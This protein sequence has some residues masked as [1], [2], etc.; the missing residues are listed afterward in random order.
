VDGSPQIHVVEAGRLEEHPVRGFRHS[1]PSASTCG[2]SRQSVNGPP[3][4]ALVH[5]NRRTT[6]AAEISPR[7]MRPWL[8]AMK[9]S[10]KRGRSWAS[11]AATLG[12]STRL[13]SASTTVRWSRANARVPPQSMKSARFPPAPRDRTTPASAVARTSRKLHGPATRADILSRPD[14]AARHRNFTR[15]GV[16]RSHWPSTLVCDENECGRTRRPARTH[17]LERWSPAS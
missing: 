16:D 12:M 14:G 17:H 4:R 3:S 13:P 5:A 1:Q 10:S 11:V 6:S 2:H 9:Q 8:E 7:A 15:P